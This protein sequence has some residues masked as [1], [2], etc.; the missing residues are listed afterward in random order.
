MVF[1][2]PELPQQANITRKQEEPDIPENVTRTTEIAALRR[3]AARAR[4]SSRVGIRLA[5][6]A[7]HIELIRFERAALQYLPHL[8]YDE[9]MEFIRGAAHLRNV[10]ARQ[11]AALLDQASDILTLCELDGIVTPLEDISEQ[12]TKS[13]YWGTIRRVNRRTERARKQG[14]PAGQVGFDQAAAR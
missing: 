12:Q 3:I 2:F 4:I 6:S 13:L 8:D 5:L 14:A 9:R 10:S 11:I 7:L 1:Y